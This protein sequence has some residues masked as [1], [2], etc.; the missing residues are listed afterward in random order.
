MNHGVARFAAAPDRRRGPPAADRDLGVARTRR[1]SWEEVLTAQRLAYSLAV[2]TLTSSVCGKRVRDTC[3]GQISVI[4]SVG[5]VRARCVLARGNAPA[6]VTA[7]DAPHGGLAAPAIAR[8]G[9]WIRVNRSS[10]STPPRA[11]RT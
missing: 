11:R 5:R 1:S 2:P 10:S 7:I 4:R 3:L 9:A 8:T 6:R